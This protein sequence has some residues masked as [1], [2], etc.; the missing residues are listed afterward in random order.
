VSITKSNTY[1]LYVKGKY[2]GAYKTEEEAAKL[3]D[4]KIIELFGTETNEILN[5]SS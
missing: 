2:I 5:F 1:Q 3:Y 4:D